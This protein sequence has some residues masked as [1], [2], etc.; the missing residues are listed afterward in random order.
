V[1]FTTSLKGLSNSRARRCKIL[2]ISSSNVKVV[3]I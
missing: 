3:L 2:A 1:A